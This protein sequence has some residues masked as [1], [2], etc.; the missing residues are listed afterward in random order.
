MIVRRKVESIR[1][2]ENGRCL[3]L[4]SVLSNDR[5]FIILLGQ[6]EAIPCPRLDEGSLRGVLSNGR[7]V[8]VIIELVDVPRSLVILLG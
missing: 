4:R 5:N 1:G 2:P 6:V 7:N 8:N 3:G